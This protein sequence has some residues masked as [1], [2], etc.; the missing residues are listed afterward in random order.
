MPVNQ[1]LA[2][3]MFST[4]VSSQKK[5]GPLG[6]L[7]TT[8]FIIPTSIEQMRKSVALRY[9]IQDD[10]IAMSPINSNNNQQMVSSSS[11][12]TP[13]SSAKTPYRTP[14]SVRRGEMGSEERILGT[15]DYLA[16]ELLLM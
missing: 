12:K 7:K 1:H 4:P 3:V 15:P 6:K 14:K 2:S 13:M 10:A 9:K 16:P 5:N 11:E 8:R